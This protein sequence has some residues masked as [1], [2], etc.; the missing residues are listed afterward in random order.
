MRAPF[1]AGK[2]RFSGCP[3]WEHTIES[4]REPSKEQ[5]ENS[6]IMSSSLQPG[7]G[8]GNVVVTDHAQVLL[9]EIK[10]L[11][12]SVG[13]IRQT[14]SSYPALIERQASTERRQLDT[15]TRFA[16]ALEKV[17]SSIIRIHDQ[18]DEVRV[19]VQD[20]THKLRGEFRDFR[21]AHR[22]EV[23]LQ[24]ST[25]VSTLTDQVRNLNSQVDGVKTETASWINKGKGVW[26]VAS[27]LWGIIQAGVIASVSFMFTEIRSMHDWRIAADHRIEVIELRHKVEDDK[28]APAPQPRPR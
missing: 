20:D 23:S 9:T 26:F 19:L 13:E 8:N 24:M 12:D 14:M 27:I 2:G 1:P 21:E 16:E 7:A 11:R 15:E 3:T 17:E 22:A 18:M 6:T 10:H 4:G 25:A 28:G 5:P